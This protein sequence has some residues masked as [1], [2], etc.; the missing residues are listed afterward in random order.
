[1]AGAPVGDERPRRNRRGVDKRT[2]LRSVPILAD[3]DDD[4]IDRLCSAVDRYHV[5]ANEWLFRMGDPS[6]AIYI[7]DSGRFAAVDVDE[8]VISEMAS[9]DSIGELGVIAGT[10][11]SADVRALR[12]GF[13]WKVAADTFTDLLTT[14]PQLQSVMLRA[15]AGMLRESRSANISRR[16]RVIGILSTGDAAAEIGRAH[17]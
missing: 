12:D 10:V 15:M 7:V 5:Q 14:T 6:D 4:Q 1:M 9:G 13:V 8:H 17:V 3:V 2:A 11:R 16:P